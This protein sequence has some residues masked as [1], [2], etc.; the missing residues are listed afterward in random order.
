MATKKPV[1]S[2][3]YTVT[4]EFDA[5]E[6][7]SEWVEWLREGH[8]ADVISGGAREAAVI[9]LGPLQFQ[10]RYVFDDAGA[11]AKYEKESAPKLRAEGLRKFPA[12]RGV[13]MSRSTGEVLFSLG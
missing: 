2:F 10:A 3:I 1:S 8:L 7:A 11:F 5:P 13:R 12:S 9:V 4:A 6:V